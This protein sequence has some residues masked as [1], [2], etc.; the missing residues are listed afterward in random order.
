MVRLSA[1][2]GDSLYEGIEDLQRLLQRLLGLIVF[3]A[4]FAAFLGIFLRVLFGVL[5]SLRVPR[6]EQSRVE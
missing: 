4:S 3:L 2:R 6:A 1:C 5:F